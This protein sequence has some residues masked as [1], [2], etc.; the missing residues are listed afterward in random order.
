MS[1][2]T[3][4]GR[5][6]SPLRLTLADFEAFW[7]VSPVSPA[8]PASS[9][10][11]APSAGR[12][13][14]DLRQRMMAWARGVTPRLR[15]SEVNVEVS[16]VAERV[17]ARP[18]RRPTRQRVLFWRDE[19]VRAEV[20]R[21]VVHG[22]RLG[23]GNAVRPPNALPEPLERQHVFLALEMGTDGVS[24]AVE[25]FPEATVDVKNLEAR[26]KE[27]E[28]ALRLD[29]AVEMLPE[30]FEVGIA[31]VGQ[32]KD[33]ER[34][35][36]DAVRSTLRRAR[37]AGGALWIG[38]HV[39]RETAVTHS[40]LLDE[41][42]EDAMV[43][44]GPVYRLI[45]WAPENDLVR[46]GELP[47]GRRAKDDGDRPTWEPRRS[48]PREKTRRKR[49]S[50]D[51]RTRTEDE[52]VTSVSPPRRRAPSSERELREAAPSTPVDKAKAGTRPVLKSTLRASLR[53]N[54]APVRLPARGR[55]TRRDA[56][57]ALVTEVD[58][59]A[60]VE[61]GTRVRVLSGPFLGKV[62]VVQDLDGK[63]GARVMLGL[64]AARLDVKDL[65]ASAEG[66][67]RPAL[68]TSHRKPLP[69][70]R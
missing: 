56:G 25:L 68:A 70:A 63:G 23:P 2:H 51:G 14:S 8:S 36:L 59:S 31:L 40:L 60:P 6:S 17:A 46:L 27:P 47:R 24:V 34:V 9:T 48:A 12:A 30:Q 20:A 54:V 33:R 26:L 50:A 3:P 45:A 22:K 4:A 21:H 18:D 37:D 29:A 64:L 38:W 5:S 55:F 52:R 1:S 19:D 44:L 49:A 58:P 43:A 65:I 67:D 16:Q 11:T 53:N 42:L 35:T 10:R 32:L 39:P 13:Q 62:G 28:H 57:R 41:Q 15:D 69:T 66:R 7:P 61:R